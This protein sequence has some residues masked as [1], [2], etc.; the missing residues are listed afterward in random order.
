V[1]AAIL[2]TLKPN[3]AGFVAAVLDGWP[4]HRAG[5]QALNSAANERAEGFDFTLKSGQ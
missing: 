5:I 2:P 4:R 1:E 3:S